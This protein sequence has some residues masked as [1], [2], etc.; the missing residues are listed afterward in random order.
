MT[1]TPPAPTPDVQRA[2]PKYDWLTLAIVTLVM[3]GL[4]LGTI[5]M[6]TFVYKD[7]M[8]A[9]TVNMAVHS[10]LT[11]TPLPEEQKKAI[12]H[13]TDRLYTAFLE[14][15]IKV[16]D[17]GNVIENLV[18]G[19]VF[20]VGAV[21][22]ALNHYVDE[23]DLTQAQNVDARLQIGRM[24]R[25][26]LA[27]Q[28]GTDKLKPIADLIRAPVDSEHTSREPQ[29]LLR[30]KL[31]APTLMQAIDHCRK[32]A[33]DANQSSEPFAFDPAVHVRKVVDGIL[34]PEDDKLPLQ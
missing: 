20:P 22:F 29:S 11:E 32:L 14:K 25:A 3:F 4:F 23:S 33:D 16:D 13:Q 19:P 6:L 34:G 1:Q 9:S 24:T 17:L 12:I 15:Q 8:I 2:K 21:Y 27:G 30:E 26:G 31:D 28:F 7:R 10:F 5:F 18:K